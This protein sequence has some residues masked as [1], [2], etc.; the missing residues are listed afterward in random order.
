MPKNYHTNFKLNSDGEYL[1]LV[2]PTTNLVVAFDPGYPEQATDISYG[3]QGVY[4]DPP[5]PGSAN[6][7]ALTDWFLTQPLIKT[8]GSTR[9]HL[10]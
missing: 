5:T 4:Y 9:M 8:E 7:Q 10:M 1:A 3:P 2:D 6:G